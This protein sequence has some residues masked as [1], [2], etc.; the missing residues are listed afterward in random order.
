MCFNYLQGGKK[1][2]NN[3][4]E[5]MRNLSYGFVQNSLTLYIE[6]YTLSIWEPDIQNSEKEPK[7]KS[8]KSIE[9]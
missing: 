3:K 9:S 6:Y 4:E 1:H 5:T 2:R 7:K 8:L